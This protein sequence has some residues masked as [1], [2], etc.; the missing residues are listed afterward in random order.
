[1]NNSVN[2]TGFIDMFID[3]DDDFEPYGVTWE[4][5]PLSELGL[6]SDTACIHNSNIFRGE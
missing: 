1:M 4:E 5:D 6:G 2:Y 3:S